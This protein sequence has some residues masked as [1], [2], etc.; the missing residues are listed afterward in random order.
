MCLRFGRGASLLLHA[1]SVVDVR[2][3]SIYPVLVP[4]E[5]DEDGGVLIWPSRPVGM[6]HALGGNDAEAAGLVV[7]ER[8]GDLLVQGR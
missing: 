7:L 8:L 1:N 6:W 4:V 2:D 3:A 5:L